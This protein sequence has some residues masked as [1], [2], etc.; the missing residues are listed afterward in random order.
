MKP[1]LLAAALGAVVIGGAAAAQTV[2][3]AEA[4]SKARLISYEIREGRYG[5]APQ[6]LTL[7]RSAT[8]SDPANADLWVALAAAEMQGLSGPNQDTADPA[9]ALAVLQTAQSHYAKALTINPQHPEALAGKGALS[10]ILAGVRMDLP[11]LNAA[12]G[13]MNRAVEI[14]PNNTTVRLQRGFFGIN[15]PAPFRDNANVEQDLKHLIS[16]GTP[17]ERDHLHVL[18]GDLYAETGKADLARAEYQAAGRQG[19]TTATM[20]TE[21]Q[22]SLAAGK[23][24]V[25]KF[26]G[27]RSQLGSNCVMCHAQ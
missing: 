10:T 16:I 21:R 13:D 18:L 14:A 11:G 4:L 12:K 25:A 6:A 26:A 3:S 5:A 20:V 2:S 27:L 8:A 17:R 15:L 19:S 7:L 23:V 1:V 24:D 22:A 9:K